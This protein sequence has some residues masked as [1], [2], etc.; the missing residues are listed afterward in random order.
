MGRQEVATPSY[1]FGSS[2]LDDTIDGV[3]VSAPINDMVALNLG[4]LRPVAEL[5]KWGVEHKPHSSIDLA[6][7]GVDVAGDGFKV[8]PWAWSA[9]WA[10]RTAKAPSTWPATDSPKTLPPTGPVSA[11]NSPCWT[12]QVHG[13]LH[14]QRQ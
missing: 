11:V 13:G 4:W 8:T 2:V 1:T 5:D 10:A 12:L 14:L 7:L 3:M 6:Y 9:L